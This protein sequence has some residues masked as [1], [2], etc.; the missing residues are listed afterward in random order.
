MQP[1][2]ESIQLKLTLNF[3]ARKCPCIAMLNAIR[4]FCFARL[5]ELFQNRQH[6][7]SR[8]LNKL[9][10]FRHFCPRWM[11]RWYANEIRNS[12]EYGMFSPFQNVNY[13]HTHTVSLFI[14]IEE[15]DMNAF[16]SLQQSSLFDKC[17][18]Q[19]VLYESK[20]K[21]VQKGNTILP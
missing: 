18:T 14:G 3:H 5:L 10:R 8:I 15:N 21:H 16:H 6:W 2:N 1:I 4:F 17:S 13:T 9:H 11:R 19:S 12:I 7:T 20:K